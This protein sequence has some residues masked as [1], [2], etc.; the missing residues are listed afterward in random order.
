MKKKIIIN[1][2]VVLI[3]FNLDK[4]FWKESKL[5]VNDRSGAGVVKT[6]HIYTQRQKT[7][8]C[9]GFY[10]KSS[11]LRISRLPMRIRNKRFR[12]I[13]PGF[14]VR[15]MLSTCAK[16]QLISNTIKLCVYRNS[17]FLIKRRNT[18]R[19]KY[20]F[21]PLQRPK[22]SLVFIRLFNKLL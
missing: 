15:S 11:V 20:L 9:L 5:F 18:A 7:R 16:L 22:N 2:E 12:P 3:L 4:M 8:F 14:V 10:L 21:G 6:F 1:G 17:V 19:S 13:R